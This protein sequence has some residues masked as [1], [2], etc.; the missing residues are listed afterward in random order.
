MDEF[1]SMQTQYGPRTAAQIEEEK[2]FLPVHNSI[3]LY[4]GRETSWRLWNHFAQARSWT[5]PGLDELSVWALVEGSYIQSIP[6]TLF[7]SRRNSPTSND[8][9]A[10]WAD[11]GGISDP[12][13]IMVFPRPDT[14]ALP[15]EHLIFTP[16][17]AYDQEQRAFLVEVVDRMLPPP[18][19]RERVA[20]RGERLTPQSIARM[21]NYNCERCVAMTRLRTKSVVFMD[22]QHIKART[23]SLVQLDVTADPICP[24]ECLKHKVD[25]RQELPTAAERHLSAEPDD[26][27]LFQFQPP[28]RQN[29]HTDGEAYFWVRKTIMYQAAVFV[30]AMQAGVWMAGHWPLLIVYCEDFPYQTRTFGFEQHHQVTTDQ[31]RI[32]FRELYA[33]HFSTQEEVSLGP[34]GIERLQQQ[35]GVIHD[36]E[37]IARRGRVALDVKPVLLCIQLPPNVGQ[38]ASRAVSLPRRV[39]LPLLITMADLETICNQREHHCAARTEE[40]TLINERP[41]QIAGWQRIFVTVQNT[42]AEVIQCESH[43]DTFADTHQ[44]EVDNEDHN[45]MQVSMARHEQYDPMTTYIFAGQ[46]PFF[47]DTAEGQATVETYCHLW[48]DRDRSCRDHRPI[49]VSKASPAT[50]QI[51]AVWRSQVQEQHMKLIPVRPIPDFGLGP[52]PT[53][54]VLDGENEQV[55]PVLFDYTSDVRVF[56]GTGLVDCSLGFP[57]VNAIFDLL[58]NECRTDTSCLI[59]ANG[60]QYVPGQT[61]MLYAGIFM[62]L[63]EQDLDETTTEDVIGTDYDPAAS[64]TSTHGVSSNASVRPEIASET[65]QSESEVLPLTATTGPFF[66]LDSQGTL[67]V[68]DQDIDPDMAL[69]WFSAIAVQRTSFPHYDRLLAELRNGPNQ[70]TWHG[71]VFVIADTD[72]S[73]AQYMQFQLDERDHLATIGHMRFVLFDEFPVHVQLEFW[74]V[75][76]NLEANEQDG[77]NDRYVLVEHSC[78]E[79]QVS[80]IVLVDDPEDAELE[81]LVVRVRHQ[82]TNLLLYIQIGKTVKCTSEDFECNIQYDGQLL[83]PGSYWPTYHGMK[84]KVI[85][86]EVEETS[87]CRVTPSQG[88][89]SRSV[90]P[91]TLQ[92]AHDSEDYVLMQFFTEAE[93]RT[94]ETEPVTR[95]PFAQ[96]HMG[97]L[98]IDPEHVHENDLLRTYIHDRKG[99]APRDA[100]TIYVWMLQLPDTKA[101]HTAQRCACTKDKSYTEALVRLWAVSF[102]LQQLAATLVHPDLQPLSLRVMPVD[103]IVTP[104]RDVSSGHKAFLIDVVGTPMPRRL[105]VLVF[106]QITVRSIAELAGARLICELPDTTCIL[107]SA[108]PQNQ[109]SWQYEQMVE[110]E[111]GSGLVLWIQPTGQVQMLQAPLCDDDNSLMQLSIAS[112]DAAMTEYM[113]IATVLGFMHFWV[114][115]GDLPEFVQSDHRRVHWRRPRTLAALRQANWRDSHGQDWRFLQIEPIPVMGGVQQPTIIFHQNTGGDPWPIL[116][117]ATRG[118]DQR[119]GTMVLNGELRPFS[120]SY[121]FGLMMPEHL[122]DRDRTCSAIM[123]GR[124]YAFWVDIPLRAGAFVELS[125]EEMTTEDSTTCTDSATQENT[126]ALTEDDA[127]EFTQLDLR[128]FQFFRCPETGRPISIQLRGQGVED[129]DVH[130]EKFVD[131]SFHVTTWHRTR[132]L[133][134]ELQALMPLGER[135]IRVFLFWFG[136]EDSPAQRLDTQWQDVWTYETGLTTARAELRLLLWEHIPPGSPYIIGTVSPQPTT[137]QQHDRDDLYLVGQAE[138]DRQVAILLVTN[139]VRRQQDRYLIRAI[140]TPYSTSREQILRDVAMTGMCEVVDCIVS[141]GASVWVPLEQHLVTI[142]MRIDLEVSLDG[143]PDHCRHEPEQAEEEMSATSDAEISLDEAEEAV[144]MQRILAEENTAT[145]ACPRTTKPDVM[146]DVFSLVQ[147]QEKPQVKD[148][149]TQRTMS[150][151]DKCAQG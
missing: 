139:F 55:I 86:R 109:Q 104:K 36:I 62:R 147:K 126:S 35:G 103:L 56:T 81:K 33:D 146:E 19:I 93:L 140:R 136:N 142:G 73:A 110:A 6:V 18:Y 97:T 105:A 137:R 90:R 100:F 51:A 20:V 43:E 134:A 40:G 46:D 117:K 119:L 141:A 68:V 87:R 116:V 76:P 107:R 108:A 37:L 44:T 89:E 9:M 7:S 31:I 50:P 53:V 151:M 106:H 66:D 3:R 115:D 63:D 16:A 25:K 15:E 144:L 21:L 29:T 85:I 34:I 114:H 47:G 128:M 98:L 88:L 72:W 70:G 127:T 26:H 130:W 82:M 48:Q 133:Q 96:S 23:G 83:P 79:D 4:R 121:I 52:Q 94:V 84:L 125:E 118:I 145:S 58:V 148:K 61:V 54:I 92:H 30:A 101:A 124:A 77:F 45:F 39:T 113:Q 8:P 59:R 57:Q 2:C 149:A 129:L 65:A 10:I 69:Q 42:P 13:A 1:T 95:S 14:F 75:H 12:E 32:R 24:G 64:A 143:S 131:E 11:L 78:P 123:D 22:H 91:R 99:E 74:L 41:T 71:I 150:W 67:M 138:T 49:V 112:N 111:H 5:H 80:I 122:C 28:P 132:E 27:A 60:R 17:S 102:P 120:V 38:I 135:G